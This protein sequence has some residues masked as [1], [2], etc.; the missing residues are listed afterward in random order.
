MLS[1]SDKSENIRRMFD[2][3]A[4]RYDFLNRLL[5]FGID[6][7]WRRKAVKFICDRD[8]SQVLDIAT[9]TGDVALEIARATLPSVKITGVDF[10]EEML[11]LGR[12]KIALSPYAERVD[13]MLAS[14]EDLP[15]YDNTFDAVT[16]AFGIRNVENKDKGLREMRRTLK[17]D[18]RIAILELSVPRS[19]LFRL[20]YKFY[21]QKLLP[22]IGGFFSCPDAYGYLPNSVN[23]FP[24][25][26][27]FADAIANAGFRNV[28]IRELF[29]GAAHIFVAEK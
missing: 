13:F 15:F 10:S 26:E 4:P 24:S 2:S 25:V 19:T 11:N 22:M 20:F 21:F 1:L 12:Q 16:I 3:I 14:C 6:Q 28:H 18:G 8:I 27:A 5:S 29:F 7:S 23:E 9:G 17:P